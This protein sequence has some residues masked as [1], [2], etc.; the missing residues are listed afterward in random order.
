MSRTFH[1]WRK[2]EVVELLIIKFSPFFFRQN[3]I[4]IVAFTNT[5]NL[6]LALTL[7]TKFHTHTKYCKLTTVKNYNKPIKYNGWCFSQDRVL[8]V[9]PHFGHFLAALTFGRVVDHVRGQALVSTTTARKLLVYICK[10]N[11]IALNKRSLFHSSNDEEFIPRPQKNI[12]RFIRSQKFVFPFEIFNT[13]S[14]AA[15]SKNTVSCGH[16]NR[17][18]PNVFMLHNYITMPAFTI[19]INTYIVA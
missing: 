18:Y 15:N 13:Y 10:S 11:H 5:F 7:E 8:S 1:I 6:F 9:L 12:K 4:F 2:V 3:I 14:R 17:G 16:N 19:H